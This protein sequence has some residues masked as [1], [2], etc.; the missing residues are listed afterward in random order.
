MQPF[1]LSD[2]C[3]VSEQIFSFEYQFNCSGIIK[4]DHV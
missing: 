4:S 1:I 2:I 3:Y